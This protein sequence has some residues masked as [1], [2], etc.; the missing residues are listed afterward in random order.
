MLALM[1]FF[2]SGSSVALE[3]L[4]K[5]ILL[6]LLLFVLVMEAFSKMIGRVVEEG[7][8]QGFGWGIVGGSGMEVSH[9]LFADDTLIF[10]GADVGIV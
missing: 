8:L 7:Y 6:S 5:E 4:G 2:F 9:V 10:C 1:G 3:D